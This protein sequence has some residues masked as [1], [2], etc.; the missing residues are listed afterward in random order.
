MLFA[1]IKKYH[2]NQ[3]YAAH[4]HT[5]TKSST[6]TV[7][8]LHHYKLLIENKASAVSKAIFIQKLILFVLFP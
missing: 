6:Q 1:N 5:S 3:I 8:G 4:T 7:V 2:K